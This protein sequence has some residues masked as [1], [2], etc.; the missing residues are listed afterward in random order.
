M[1]PEGVVFFA[2]GLPEEEQESRLRDPRCAGIGLVV[3]G[4]DWRS[5]TANGSVRR[6]GR[7]GGVVNFYYPEAA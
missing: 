4:T 1:K 5:T 7:L 2:G 3:E 6:N